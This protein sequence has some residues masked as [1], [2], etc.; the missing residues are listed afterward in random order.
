MTPVPPALLPARRRDVALANPNGKRSRTTCR[1][2]AAP[3]KLKREPPDARV[4]VPLQ[5]SLVQYGTKIWCAF[6]QN[7]FS[8]GFEDNIP[9]TENN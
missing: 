8:S 4:L 2:T 3:I 6:H 9:P 1:T 5:E 7:G